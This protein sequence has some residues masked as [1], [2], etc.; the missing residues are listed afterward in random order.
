MRVVAPAGEMRP[1]RAR[2]PPRRGRTLREL[3]VGS[4]G[5]LGVITEAT[6]K[7]RPLPRRAPLRGLVV[8]ELRRG[9]EALRVLAQQDAAPDVARLS[10]E[11]E[12]RPG[13]RR[14]STG[15]RGRAR[16]QGATCGCAATS[17]AASRSSAGRATRTT[18]SG[19]GY[20]RRAAARR[21]RAVARAPRPGEAWLRGRYEGPYQRDVL[22]DHDVLVETLETATSW[23]NL[24]ALYGARRRR[25]AASHCGAAADGLCHVSHL[26]PLGRVALLH[27][28]GPAGEDGARASGARPRAP[29]REAIVAAGGTITHHHAVGRDHMPWMRP[30]SASSAWSCCAPPRSGSIRRDHEPRQAAA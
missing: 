24:T 28:P 2:R 21:R 30:R 17:A 10:D 5:V 14:R 27:L 29:P 22:L 11:D 13:V 16:R 19:A 6:L 25:A 3:L 8:P 7:V 23:S 15:R 20:A 12:T 1:A 4:E 9:R 18:S 26:Y